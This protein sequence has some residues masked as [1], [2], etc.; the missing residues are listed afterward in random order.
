MND[1]YFPGDSDDE[2]E[3]KRINHHNNMIGKFAESEIKDNF[4]IID[5]Q[6]YLQN[7]IDLYLPNNWSICIGLLVI[8]IILELLL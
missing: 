4:Q 3:Q 5:H 7:I 8:I 1:F 2:Y 6:L